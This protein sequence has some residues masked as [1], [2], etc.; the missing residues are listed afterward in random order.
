MQCPTCHTENLKE[1]MY[2]YRCGADLAVPST[3]LVPVSKQVPSA[4]HNPQLPRVAAS[5]GAVA[6]GVGIEL[7][8]RGLVAR[9]SKPSRALAGT[10]PTLD[11]LEDILFPRNKVERDTRK[12]K[13]AKRFEVEETVIYMRK[14]IRRG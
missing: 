2:C 5:V 13:R 9:A 14:V 1:E 12:M 6:L 7:L 3:S 11:A 8:R 4:L 10:Q